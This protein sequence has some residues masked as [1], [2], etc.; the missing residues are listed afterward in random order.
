MR[1]SVPATIANFGPGF[2]VF[3]LC[4]E[5]PRDFIRV[6]LSDEIEVKVEGYKVP[7]EPDKNVASVSALSLL[8][9]AGVESGFKMK[10]KKGIRPKSGLGS[11]GASALGGALAVARLLDIDDKEIILRAALEG[12]KVA[13]GS[14]HGDNIVP[15]LFGG[16][17]VLKSLFPLEVF[18]IDAKLKLVVILPEV[19][20]STKRAREVLPK[21]VPLSDA[22][23]N[24]ALASSLVL[25]L[26]NGDIEEVGK[27]LDDYLAMPYR[28]P[29]IPWFDKIRK[30]ALENGAYGVSISG[31]GPAVFALGENL[32]EIGRAIVG[33]FE[34]ERINAEY[35]I[36]KV[37]GGAE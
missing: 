22:V 28:K 12:E 30:A 2:D 23:R 15:A 21:H 27:L 3:G 4:L 5:K 6:K 9:Q 33:A 37:G 20:V 14:P 32:D 19:E 8:R 26:E 35:F 24:L 34:E 36:S 7:E 29:L 16:F 17:V 10:I 18:K 25:A 11:S 13:S 31:S 1:V